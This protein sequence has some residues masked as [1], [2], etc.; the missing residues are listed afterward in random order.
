MTAATVD[1]AKKPRTDIDMAAQKARLLELKASTEAT[2]GQIAAQDADGLNAVGTDR[3]ELSS[4]DNHP[5]DGGTD[6]QI[7][8]QDAALVENE[9]NILAQIETAL[10]RIEDGTYGYSER[11]GNPIPTERLEAIPYATL[12]VDESY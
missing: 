6:M 12:T 9:R 8:E 3:A 4:A 11:S 1:T 2:L 10:A 7:R 5:A